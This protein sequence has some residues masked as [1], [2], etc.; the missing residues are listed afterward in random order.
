MFIASEGRTL[1][2]FHCKEIIRK[3]CR[4]S[5]CQDVLCII[6]CNIKKNEITNCITLEVNKLRY[7]P[8]WKRIL[9]KNH[10]N[11][12]LTF[13]PLPEIASAI[14]I[15]GA[16]ASVLKIW[17]FVLPQ[18]E[19]GIQCS[20][21]FLSQLPVALNFAACKLQLWAS[22][23]PF[24]FPY[25]PSENSYL[26]FSG[27]SGRNRVECVFSIHY[28][29]LEIHILRFFKSWSEEATCKFSSIGIFFV[30]LSI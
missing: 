16:G 15:W 12:S 8:E 27:V 6:F 4:I 9:N 26:S 23:C 17:F 10:S 19:L 20:L 25:G 24:F 18:Q 29:S 11:F 30:H 21:V 22:L 3:S 7:I 1:P 14:I 5:M 2:E 13:T 28:I